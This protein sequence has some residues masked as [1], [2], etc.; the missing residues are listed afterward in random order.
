MAGVNPYAKIASLKVTDNYKSLSTS[1]D[2]FS[3]LKAIDFSIDNGIKII[4]ASF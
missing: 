3:I 1:F 2:D 4:N